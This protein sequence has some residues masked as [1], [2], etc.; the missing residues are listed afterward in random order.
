ML[1]H[2]PSSPSVNTDGFKFMISCIFDTYGLN[3]SFRNT[4]IITKTIFIWTVSQNDY[5]IKIT[6]YI[7]DEQLGGRHGTQNCVFSFI[8]S[9]NAVL[10]LHF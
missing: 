2:R 1:R 5:P 3:S 10:S 9:Y 4:I 8:F 6:R 7:E